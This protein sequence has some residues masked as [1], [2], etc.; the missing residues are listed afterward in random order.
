MCIRDRDDGSVVSTCD[1]VVVFDGSVVV[2]L[3]VVVP[4]VVVVVPCSGF[5]VAPRCDVVSVVVSSGVGV[6]IVVVVVDVGSNVVSCCE[7]DSLIVV[8][9]LVDGSGVVSV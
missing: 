2:S 1:V 5:A 8:A 3:C 6:S 4:F 9:V 7:E